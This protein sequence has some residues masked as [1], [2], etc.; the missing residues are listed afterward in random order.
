MDL[1]IKR[2][3]AF[4]IYYDIM[5]RKKNI[6]LFIFKIVVYKLKNSINSLCFNQWGE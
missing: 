1:N 5:I 6:Y 2:L 3:L 4:E